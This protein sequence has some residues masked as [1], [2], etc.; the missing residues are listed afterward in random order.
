M[1]KSIPIDEQY[2]ATG[3]PLLVVAAQDVGARAKSIGIDEQK[4]RDR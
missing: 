3:I 1:R 2:S 4:Y